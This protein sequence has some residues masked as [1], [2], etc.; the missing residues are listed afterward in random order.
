MTQTETTI[1]EARETDRREAE[2]ER[3]NREAVALYELSRQIS[4][5]ADMDQLLTSI[6]ANAVWILE[7]QFAGIVLIDPET[8][9]ASW[10]A[11]AGGRSAKRGE[12]CDL[13]GGTV[14][15]R[16]TTTRLPVV[17][18][19]APPGVS[20]VPDRELLRAEG[21]DALVGIPIAQKEM[22]YGILLCGSRGPH[23][24]GDNQIR[25]LSNLCDTA[26]LALD[27]MRLYLSIVEHA[28]KLKALT[29]RLAGIQ[30]EERGRISREL[31]DGVGQSLTAVRVN[32]EL[33][34]R[35]VPITGGPALER[36]HGLMQI[37]DE[38]LQE[39]R[40]LAFDLRP[41]VLDHFGLPAAL[42][43]FAE[44]FQRQTGTRVRLE[45]PEE[46]GRWDPRI[47]ATVFRVVQESLTNVAKHAG[48]TEAVVRLRPV[49][50]QLT[51]EVSDNGH[52]FTFPHGRTD[53]A[54]E[55]G[56]GILNMKERVDELHGTFSLRSA[57]GEGT[58]IFVT[59]PRRR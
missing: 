39:I 44:R 43:I 34:S 30:E 27:N 18:T 5:S 11:I 8:G 42:R 19:H 15:G 17:V 59:I 54:S 16:V 22:L 7:Y 20:D 21:L 28:K 47:E 3:R 36:L 13:G 32:L 35:E 38:T 1:H 12:P 31:H 4:S 58:R 33:L 10:R 52:G 14:A 56:L 2:L 57:E 23:V 55:G 9:G 46:I 26:A 25:F 41:T 50:E 6:V 53:G 40:Q 49:D 29:S 48:A 24:P 37:I 51:L 45:S